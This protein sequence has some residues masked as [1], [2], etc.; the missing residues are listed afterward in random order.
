MQ[1]AEQQ[2]SIERPLHSSRKAGEPIEDPIAPHIAA[3]LT[4]LGEDVRRPGLAD[5]S[6]R[7][8]AAMR[9]LAGGYESSVEEVVGR[10][11]FAA[12]GSGAIAVRDVEF[13][14]LCEH[15]I[16]P[17]FGRVH[18]AYLPGDRIIGLSKIPRIVD[19]FARRLQVQE[20]LTEQVADALVEVLA[21]RGVIVVSE[22][23][24]LCMAMRG[25]QKQHSATTTLAT[26]GACADDPAVRDHVLALLNSGAGASPL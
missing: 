18:I 2:H 9:F 15:H 7:Y 20:R 23:R 3:I 17:F 6:K 1:A 21:P 24:H 11:V 14:S 10:G 4:H 19:L 25:V 16:L 12:E 22:A 13:F 5:T 8:A 26:R